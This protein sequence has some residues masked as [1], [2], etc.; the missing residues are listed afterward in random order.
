MIVCD[1]G[2]LLAAANAQDHH[3]KVCAALLREAA[4][5]LL[6]PSPVIAEVCQLLERRRGSRS[7]AAFLRSF[8]NGLT[9]VELT[10]ADLDRMATL[11][12]TYA[13]LPLGTVDASVITVAERL[14]IE[15]VATL[16]RRHFTIVRPRHVAALALVPT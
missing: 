10:N 1:T 2:P 8:R 7:E 11:V 3:H 14:G 9:L 12:E 6:V 4:G 5:P 16:D 15:Q 13:S